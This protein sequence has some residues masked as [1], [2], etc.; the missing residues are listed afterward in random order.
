MEYMLNIIGLAFRISN[1]KTKKKLAFE[2]NQ[3]FS[4]KSPATSHFDDV[5]KKIMTLSKRS[6][7]LE[8]LCEAKSSPLPGHFNPSKARTNRVKDVSIKKVSFGKHNCLIGEEAG[9]L[10]IRAYLA[11]T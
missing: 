4:K 9:G 1:I 2:G 6:A 7:S 10:D 5:I 11:S 8:I 3:F